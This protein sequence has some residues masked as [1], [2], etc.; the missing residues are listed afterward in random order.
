MYWNIW[1]EVGKSFQQF[2]ASYDLQ[3]LL[4]YFVITKCSVTPK[5]LWQ[6]EDAIRCK[7]PL[8]LQDDVD[9]LQ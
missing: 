3:V 5:S 8:L 7:R 6:M 1:S 2:I 4:P 9:L